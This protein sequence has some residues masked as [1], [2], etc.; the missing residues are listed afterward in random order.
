MTAQITEEYAQLLEDLKFIDSFHPWSQ[1]TEQRRL[2][3]QR[4]RERDFKEFLLRQ[5]ER[6]RGVQLNSEEQE[7]EERWTR[8]MKECGAIFFDDL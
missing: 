5:E 7:R 6:L 8:E 1:E 2:E 4:V 3:D